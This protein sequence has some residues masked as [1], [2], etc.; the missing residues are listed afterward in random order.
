MKTSAVALVALECVA[1][2]QAARP[3]GV[4][5]E[6]MHNPLPHLSL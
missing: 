5:P 6:C 4:G 1:L 2:S 3:R